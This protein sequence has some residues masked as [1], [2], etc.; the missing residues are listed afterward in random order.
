MPITQANLSVR[1]S[2]PASGTY[3]YW[4]TVPDPTVSGRR[5]IF[6]LFQQ[7]GSAVRVSSPQGQPPPYAGLWG[8]PMAARPENSNPPTRY[9]V[10]R[11]PPSQERRASNESAGPSNA[12]PPVVQPTATANVRRDWSICPA[13]NHGLT[14]YFASANR[15][16]GHYGASPNCYIPSAS[17]V[18]PSSPFD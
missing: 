16:V 1:P 5:V 15:Y 13:P 17:I 4:L 2:D 3:A 6:P 8:T 18:R 7:D 12:S 9:I 14:W 10:C 11:P